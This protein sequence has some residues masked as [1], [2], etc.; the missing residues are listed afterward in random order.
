LVRALER[1]GLD[2]VATGSL[3]GRVEGV[4]SHNG[5]SDGRGHAS[6]KHQPRPTAPTGGF[7]RRGERGVLV[8]G[9]TQL[10]GELDVFGELLRIV[11]TEQT[12]QLPFV[13]DQ[14]RMLH[15]NLDVV[16]HHAS[17]L[18]ATRAESAS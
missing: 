10:R 15:S 17:P 9:A 14:V 3:G 4:A 8:S 2:R 6:G 7:D 12:V 5:H 1:N 16:S 13:A 11:L 18:P